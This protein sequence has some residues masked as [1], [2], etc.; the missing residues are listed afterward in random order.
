MK[1]TTMKDSTMKDSTME[2]LSTMKKTEFDDRSGQS[3][4][5]AVIRAAAKQQH[6]HS[7]P[8]TACIQTTYYTCTV[9]NGCTRP[10]TCRDR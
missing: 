2:R 5:S 9:Y 8:N 6:I 3:Y 10:L 1:K 7:T 4:S